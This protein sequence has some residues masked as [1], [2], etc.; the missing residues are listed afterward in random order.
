M[1]SGYPITMSKILAGE[2]HPE[3]LATATHLPT[4]RRDVYGL[5][6]ELSSLTTLVQDFNKT[7]LSQGSSSTMKAESKETNLTLR[8]GLAGLPDCFRTL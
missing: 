3:A 2:P 6:H 4:V 1:I 5:N 7:H 8:K